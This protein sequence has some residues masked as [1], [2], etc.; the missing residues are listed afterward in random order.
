MSIHAVPGRLTIGVLAVQGSFSEHEAL[1]AAAGADARQ[2]RTSEQLADLDGLIL[3]GGESSTVGLVAGESGLLDSMRAAISAGL[4]VFGTC[5]GMIM[6]ARATTGGTQPLL[7][8]IDMTVRRNAYGR[9]QASFEA[10][11]NV[12]VLGE[13]TLDGVFIRAPWIEEAGPEVQTLASYAGRPVLVRQG[14]LLAAAFHPEFTE[15]ARL[16]AYF[17][18]IVRERRSEAQQNT[19]GVRVRA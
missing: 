4:P 9:Q 12:P 8:G 2:V 14:D 13:S 16:H 17:L 19:G 10:P 3:P 18:D 1:V 15:D 7:G 11:L 6:L 5:A